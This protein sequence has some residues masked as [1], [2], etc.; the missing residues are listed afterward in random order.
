MIG[1]DTKILKYESR[2]MVYRTYSIWT[3]FEKKKGTNINHF[4]AKV[5]PY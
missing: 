4:Y 2:H 5:S 1:V 3:K